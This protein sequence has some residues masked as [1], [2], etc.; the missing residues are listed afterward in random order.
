MTVLLG[1]IVGSGLGLGGSNG[2]LEIYVSWVMFFEGGNCLVECSLTIV[3]LSM[4]LF[5]C[6]VLVRPRS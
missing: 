6:S 4:H 1:G 5:F 2:T 3:L